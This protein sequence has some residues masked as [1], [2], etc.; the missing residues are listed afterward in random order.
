MDNRVM[1]ADFTMVDLDSQL[2][3]VHRI[4]GAIADCPSGLS[5]G[6]VSAIADS[7]I[8]DYR[9]FIYRFF[10]VRSIFGVANQTSA[11]LRPGGSAGASMRHTPPL[12][13]GSGSF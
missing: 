6:D 11:Q 12:R 10:I 9:F 4:D 8:V 1:A 5:I 3:I 13:K 7:P 2:P